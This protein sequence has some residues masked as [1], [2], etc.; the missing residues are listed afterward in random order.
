M[1][2]L[3]DGYEEIDGEKYDNI[4]EFKNYTFNKLKDEDVSRPNL[5]G[6]EIGD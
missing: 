3:I 5:T 1:L 6:Y 4:T 2:K